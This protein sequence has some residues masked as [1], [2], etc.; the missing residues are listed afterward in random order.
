MD[1]LV[2]AFENFIRQSGVKD[3][4]KV[5][6]ISGSLRGL[7]E[8]ILG[9][10]VCSFSE[11]GDFLS[12]WRAYGN[13][14]KGLSIGLN[15]TLLENDANDFILGKCVY[16]CNLQ[17]Q[18]C[19]RFL[20]DLL[21]GVEVRSLEFDFPQI[22]LE[23]VENF[24]YVVGIF[25]KHPAF[26]YEKEWRLVSGVNS[27]YSPKWNFRPTERGLSSFLIL[28][29]PS[30]FSRERD[31]ESRETTPHF[32]FVLGPKARATPTAQILQAISHRILGKGY[33]VQISGIPYID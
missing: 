25:L 24:I 17:Y 5:T 28:E 1:V 8:K 30:V 4:A 26:E 27:L 23:N 6:K 21:G 19:L 12:Q 7:G 22:L 2:H 32:K 33:G 16:D 9:H 10:C 29:L 13:D 20:K 31:D 15:S 3:E 18:I 11:E 14:G